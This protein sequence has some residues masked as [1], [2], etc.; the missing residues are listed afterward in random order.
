[1]TCIDNIT[2]EFPYTVYA[3]SIRCKASRRNEDYKKSVLGLGCVIKIAET[4]R[5]KR[6]GRHIELVERTVAFNPSFPVGSFCSLVSSDRDTCA[7][8][9]RTHNDGRTIE[10]SEEASLRDYAKQ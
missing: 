4:N 1:M 8:S 3:Y 6:V 9:R 5:A 10:N 7:K 2:L